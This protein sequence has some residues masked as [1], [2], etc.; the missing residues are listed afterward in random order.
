MEACIWMALAATFGTWLVTALGAATV[1]FFSSPKEKTL[2]LMLGFSAGLHLPQ[3]PAH[4]LVRTPK[5]QS[6]DQK[7]YRCHQPGRQPRK[8]LRLGDG[9]LQQ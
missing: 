8:A 2:N 1:V 3:C 9:R 6:A 4:Q 5:E 7:P